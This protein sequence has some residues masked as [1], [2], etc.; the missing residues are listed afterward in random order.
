[1]D[2]GL[3]DE[4]CATILHFM[5]FHNI[6]WN[7]YPKWICIYLSHQNFFVIIVFFMTMPWTCPW[8]GP[9]ALEHACI[10][11]SSWPSF[12][13]C[14]QVQLPLLGQN[15]MNVCVIM[16]FK[17]CSQA[18][19]IPEC[20]PFIYKILLFSAVFDCWYVVQVKLCSREFLFWA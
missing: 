15:F 9:V 17:V 12:V 3:F 1:M 6:C 14:R 16:I 8:T 11:I 20:W 18:T 10:S 2:L 19:H 4:W 13:Q 5:R 7:H